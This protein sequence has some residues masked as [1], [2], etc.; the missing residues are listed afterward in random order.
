[1]TARAV[2]KSVSVFGVKLSSSLW[3]IPTR[4]LAG[5]ITKDFVARFIH[6]ARETCR[7]RE[8]RLAGKRRL[9]DVPRALRE[10]REILN[11]EMTVDRLDSHL[12][13]FFD[14]HQGDPEAG[15]MRPW[16]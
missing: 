5:V 4:L 10:L 6:W 16:N 7:S 2:V 3:V 13:K 1:M 9:M 8:T 11:K 14:Y 15:K 12:A